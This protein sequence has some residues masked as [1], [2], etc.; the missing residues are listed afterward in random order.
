MPFYM[1]VTGLE[2]LITRMGTLEDKGVD[3]ASA[4][5]YEGAGIMADAVTK[6]VQG[7][8]TEEFRY[9]KHGQRL[10]SPEEKALILSARRGVTK[11]KKSKTSV[12]T[13]IGFQKS[14]YGDLGGKTRPIPVVANSIESGTSFMK[15]QPF[16]RTAVEKTAPTAAGVIEGGIESRFNQLSLD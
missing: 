2:E 11:F 12:E 13:S 3:I 10:P 9:T 14:G 16:F 15:P 6:A 1:Q 8:V 4:A 7:I 5:L